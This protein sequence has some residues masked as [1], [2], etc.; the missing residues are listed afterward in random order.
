MITVFWYYYPFLRQAAHKTYSLLN[1]QKCSLLMAFY[2]VEK[3][4]NQC[5]AKYVYRPFGALQQGLLKIQAVL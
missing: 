1:A 3:Y 4:N 5:Q 2:R